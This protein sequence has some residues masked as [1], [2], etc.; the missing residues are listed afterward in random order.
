MT[1]RDWSVYVE[2]DAT[3][4]SDATHDEVLSA[5][6]AHAAQTTTAANGNFAVQLSVSAGGVVEAAQAGVDLV[7]GALPAGLL[8]RQAVGIEAVTEAEQERRCTGTEN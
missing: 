8:G 3:D 2:I 4:A 1:T 5:L 7:L 6:S